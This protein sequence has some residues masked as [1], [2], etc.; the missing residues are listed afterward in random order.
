MQKNKF[1]FTFFLL[2]TTLM[3]I[4][5]YLLGQSLFFR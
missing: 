1:S 4:V 5:T 3:V 2:L